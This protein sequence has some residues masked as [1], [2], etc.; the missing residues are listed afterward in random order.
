MSEEQ[1]QKMMEQLENQNPVRQVITGIAITLIF[2]M[3]TSL[4]SAS[5]LKKKYD[6]NNPNQMR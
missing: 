6:F 1:R 5:F 4:I 2:G 3:L